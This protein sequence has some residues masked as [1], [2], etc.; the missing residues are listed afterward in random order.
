M[1]NSTI[2]QH[3]QIG[4]ELIPPF[5]QEPLGSIMHL[6]SWSKERLPEYVWIGL[7]RES[8]NSKK[9]FFN[10]FYYLKEYMLNT[11]SEPCDK[12]SIIL[13]LDSNKKTAL[14]NKIKE[15]F[16]S[17]VLDPIIVVSNFDKET[18]NSFI[19]RSK[20][21]NQRIEKIVDI[22]EKMYDRHS[23]FAMDIRYCAL[24]LK[25]N[26]ICFLKENMIIKDAIQKYPSAEKD[27]PLLDAYKVSLSSMEGMDF[28]ESSYEYSKYFYEEMYL[29]TDC[30]P[31]TIVYPESCNKELLIDKIKELKNL[32]LKSE[33]IKADDKR[34]VIIGNIT[35]VYKL[36]KEIIDNELYMSITS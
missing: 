4:K 36:A 23:D 29:M 24:I 15:I 26:K 11:F 6:C 5:M 31:K 22:I 18:R 25:I 10:K 33:E 3:K 2:K 13:K 7:L 19:D 28:V 27:N 30:K 9:D 32:I 21:N 1:K 17:N 14:Y 12:F 35:Y 16:G 34:D 8:C 20:S